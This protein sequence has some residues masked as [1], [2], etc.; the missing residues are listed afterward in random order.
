MDGTVGKVFMADPTTWPKNDGVRHRL[1][2]FFA[3]TAH[4]LP[5]FQT[6]KQCTSS[7]LEHINKPFVAIIT[8]TRFKWKEPRSS[9][10]REK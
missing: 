9:R 1:A 6:R 2:G 3:L 7:R 4:Q 8:A 10:T 5:G